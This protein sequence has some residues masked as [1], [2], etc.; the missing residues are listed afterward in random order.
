MVAMRAGGPAMGF[1][2]CFYRG[3]DHESCVIYSGMSEVFAGKVYLRLLLL[4][5][6]GNGSSPLIRRTA[7]VGVGGY[8]P[9]LREQGA[10]GCEDYLMQILVARTWLVGCV[11]AYLIGYRW[12]AQAMSR[13]LTRMMRSHLATL[14]QVRQR[15]PETPVWILAASEAK[16]RA[17]FAVRYLHGLRPAR[18]LGE[19]W[20]AMRLDAS[21]AKEAAWI[22]AKRISQTIVRRRLSGLVSRPKKRERPNFLSLD[23]LLRSGRSAPLPLGTLINELAKQ[24]AILFSSRVGEPDA[25]AYGLPK[26]A[27]GGHGYGRKVEHGA[28]RAC[29]LKRPPPL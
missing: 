27:D 21:S 22:T 25:D 23:P 14:D 8:D 4:N 9:S 29:W 6:V 17:T 26:A 10:Q 15:L 19:F 5:F 16:V 24:E 28:L 7:L 3:I 1:V 20:R 2:Y 12:S 13:D 11:P 18:A